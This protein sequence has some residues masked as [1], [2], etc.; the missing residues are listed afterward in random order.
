[1]SF[2]K[3]NQK[4]NNASTIKS[5]AK[6]VLD[7]LERYRKKL[8]I[9]LIISI[10]NVCSTLS[11]PLLI[12]NATDCILGP[13]HV[14][15]STIKIL[16]LQMLV[17]ILLSASMQWITGVINNHI[18]YDCS[19]RL[20]METFSHL[21]HVCVSYLDT[22]PHGDILSR[23]IDDINQFADGLLMF[24]TQF[25]SGII[26]I[27][28][29]LVLMLVT[30]WHIAI[31]VIAL[32]PLSALVARFIARK[33]FKLFQKQS[34]NR[35]QLTSFINETID[36]Q[37]LI[38]LFN[39]ENNQIKSFDK[40]NE[41]LQKSSLLS[42][43]YS[44]TV[45]PTTRFI[46]ALVYATVAL[47]GSFLVLNK[48]I[49]VGNLTCMLAYANQY[50]KPFN[51]ISG[52]MA[53]LQNSFVCASRIFELLDS[54]IEKTLSYDLAQTFSSTTFAQSHKHD[55]KFN[56]VSFS[57]NH[58]KTSPL[59]K[60]I[61]FDISPGMHVALVGPTGCGKSTL[62]NLLMRFYDYDDGSI[63]IDHVDIT[64]RP[65]YEARKLWGM[66][67]QQTWLENTSIRENIRFGKPHASNSEV[68]RA[69]QQAFAHNF[70]MRLPQGYDTILS[71]NGEP[72]SEGQK[73]LLCIA[74]VMLS[75]PSMLILDEATSSIDTR[76]ETLIQQAISHMMQGR[77]S[78]TVA[79]R[80]S[81]I[82]SSDL[83]LVMNDGKIVERG[84][85]ETLLAKHGYYYNLYS[86]QFEE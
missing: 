18:V 4:R 46:N 28:L 84:T 7:Y 22:H 26:T 34:E 41:S 21:E 32:T 61:C 1:M 25:F 30:D 5:V 2:N 57:Y 10:C 77:T 29:T 39:Q 66:V 74:R 65:R 48:V 72:L 13:G 56:Q 81:T 12:G 36:N 47:I 14:Q 6:K 43:F 71:N 45:N 40:L 85:H 52:V 51:E 78:F 59:L 3:A 82:I 8:L 53:E 44:S 75:D 19:Y 67:L 68:E 86:S 62:I 9:S 55:L 69:A 17:L 23:I 27:L 31:S 15:F 38:H 49:T 70:I 80:L 11:L 73:Q 35:G 83:I 20:R 50:T 37:K 63:E 58:D 64:T 42:M 24:M 16:L 54:P 33:T 60:N 76:T 79:H